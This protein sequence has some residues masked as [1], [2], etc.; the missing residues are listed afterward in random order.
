MRRESLEREKR[1]LLER[2]KR[3]GVVKSERIAR[4]FLKVPRELFV[5]PR[6]AARAYQD[7]PLPIGYGQ[8]ISAP[9]MVLIMT[10]RLD[11]R[12]GDK[13]LEVG[14]GSGYQAALLAE[15][16]DPT[17]SGPGHVYTIERLPEL[18]E[19]AR[20]NLERAGYADRVTVIVG[21]GSLG[22]PESAPYDGIIVTAAAPKIPEPLKRQLKIGGRIVAP[23]GDLFSQVLYVGVK[24][25]ESELELREDVPCVF[26]PLIGKEGWPEEIVESNSGYVT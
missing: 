18:A 21:D 11:P 17:G 9:H 2:L 15:L 4:A 20:R 8:T 5:P 16:V 19:R 24:V 6:L 10:E 22:Y 3:E 25:S 13:I 1:E 7:I 23:V 26:V 12:E 14:T